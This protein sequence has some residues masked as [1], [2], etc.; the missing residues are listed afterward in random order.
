MA[1][2]RVPA[3]Q[4]GTP[5]VRPRPIGG[6]APGCALNRAGQGRPAGSG[7]KGWDGALA[8]GANARVT[9]ATGS[10]APQGT[11]RPKDVQRDLASLPREP[12]AEAGSFGGG[13]GAYGAV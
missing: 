2:S 4:A 13:R 6:G 11:G 5:V 7:R 3:R 1:G 12:A 10:L 8:G 9:W